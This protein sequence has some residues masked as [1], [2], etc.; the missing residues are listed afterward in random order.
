MAASPP[1]LAVQITRTMEVLTMSA[2]GSLRFI[3]LVGSIL[4]SIGALAFI[5]YP[6]H[7]VYAAGLG[8]RLVGMWWLQLLEVWFHPIVLFS[9]G[10]ILQALV[11]IAGRI[12]ALSNEASVGTSEEG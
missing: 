10:V 1:C 6:I 7:F 9:I 12:G 3:R 5:A 8:G 2:T 4:I 11:E